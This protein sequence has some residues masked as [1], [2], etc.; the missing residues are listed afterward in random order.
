MIFSLG[1]VISRTKS[2]TSIDL[3]CMAINFRFCGDRLEDQRLPPLVSTTKL[4][5]TFML[6]VLLLLTDCISISITGYVHEKQKSISPTA[7]KHSDDN[8]LLSGLCFG[9][10]F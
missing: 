10:R 1:F 2:L 6:L 9:C 7:T 5:S 8:K 3:K 4:S